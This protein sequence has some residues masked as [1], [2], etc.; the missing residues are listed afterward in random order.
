[1]TQSDQ[2][3]SKYL[4]VD[5]AGVVTARGRRIHV[6]NSWV[7]KARGVYLAGDNYYPR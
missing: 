6:N 1:M 4:A 2:T 7:H 5:S 3:D